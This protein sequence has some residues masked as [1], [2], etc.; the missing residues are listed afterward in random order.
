MFATA[1]SLVRRGAFDIEQIRWSGLQQGTFGL[2]D[3]LYSRKGIGVPFGLL[4]LTWLGFVVPWF[5]T[6]SVSLLFNAIVTALTAVILMAYL[7]DLGFS[8]RVGLIV[9][10]TFGL[11]TLAWPY[12]KSLFSDPFSGFLLL[13]AAFLL[14]KIGTPSGPQRGE[15]TLIAPSGGLGGPTS[16]SITLTY[17]FLAGLCL[18]WNVATR[19]AEVL[20]LPIYGLLLLYY[21][22]QRNQPPN[23]NSS[24][25]SLTNFI[26][27]TWLI[28]TAFM[29]PILFTGLFLISFNIAR[30][31]DAFDTGYLPNETFSGILWQGVLGQLISPG[32]GLLLYSP[33]FI[34][35]F[36]GM[37]WGWRRFRTET[38]VAL[39]IILVHLLLY[40]KWFMWHGGY[41]WGPRFMIPTLPFWALFLGPVVDAIWPPSNSPQRGENQLA[42]L[43][44]G[45]IEG[46]LRRILSLLY[47]TLAFL[48]FIPQFLT[49]SIHFTPFLDS[50][51]DTGLPLFAPE[52]FFQWQY[53]PLRSAWSYIQMDSLDLA[54]AWQ[55]R[56]NGLLLLVLLSNILVTGIALWQ[57]TAKGQRSF[58]SLLLPLLSTA[59]T[60]I[61]LLSYT[62]TLPTQNLQQVVKGLNAAVHNNDVIITNDPEIAGSFAELYK[63]RAPVLGLHNGDFPL[64]NDV[65]DRLAEIKAQY[66]HIWWVPSWHP[67][68]ESGIEQTLQQDNFRARDDNF[69]GQRLVLF[70]K[71]INLAPQL[72]TEA[73]QFEGGISLERV[74]YT[75][76]IKT[77][78]AL[79]VALEWETQLPISEDY[80]VFLHLTNTNGDL[81]A[82]ADGQP[83]QWTRPTSTW[84][85]GE[86]IPDQYGLWIP[87]DTSLTT[88]QLRIGLYRPADGQR[89]LLADGKDAVDL[90]V[91]I[92]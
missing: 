31:G 86:T 85:V 38:V 83:A 69:E 66:E 43:P 62:H 18:G 51:L 59:I 20:F 52:T 53:S 32:R 58:L 14:R 84:Q 36:V 45:G 72:A 39:S 57:Q 10:L 61:F 79:L 19:Y 40:G 87:P 92:R 76:Q 37:W 6:I 27:S 67:P 30:Y 74:D 5:G 91:E 29:I 49:V 55:G 46:G 44:E 73:A 23:K 35:S 50:L 78:R 48:G 47:L 89:L 22:Y 21:L 63:G 41:A 25:F 42:F 82:Q 7:R 70:A 68:A 4:P 64:P 81:I 33:I 71:P 26:K 24:P 90:V 13:A 16:K 9:A 17:A 8:Q 34:L 11:T 75:P 15:K 65:T 54:W 1:E 28:I 80:N 77:G 3:L 56:F 88:Y 2:D 12:A 60:L